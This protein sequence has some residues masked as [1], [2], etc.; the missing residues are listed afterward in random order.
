MLK[1]TFIPV[2]FYSARNVGLV[3]ITKLVSDMSEAKS[4][5]AAHVIS[6]IIEDDAFDALDLLECEHVDS[7][8][9]PLMLNELSLTDELQ[10]RLIKLLFEDYL[11]QKERLYSISN[12]R[13]DSLVSS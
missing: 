8:F 5:L 2:S 1:L 7:C 6:Q 13:L 3:P 12:C 4:V 10:D 9:T 11:A